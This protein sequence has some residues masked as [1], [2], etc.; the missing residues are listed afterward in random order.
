MGKFLKG[1]IFNGKK[2]TITP[3]GGGELNNK[4]HL[5]RINMTPKKKREETY[6]KERKNGPQII[7]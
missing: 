4:I 6:K 3:N 1:N 5:C 7:F 2:M